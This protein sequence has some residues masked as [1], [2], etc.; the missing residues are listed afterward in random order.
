METKNNNFNRQSVAL[1]KNIFGIVMDVK[2]GIREH[3][4]N[5]SRIKPGSFQPITFWS[6]HYLHS[7]DKKIKEADTQ[8]DINNLI[9]TKNK[10]WS[11]V[12][13]E[14]F[15]YNI[16]LTTVTDNNGKTFNY[17]VSLPTVE[18]AQPNFTKFTSVIRAIGE[19]AK[20]K[21]NMDYIYEIAKQKSEYK[22]INKDLKRDSKNEKL[23][24]KISL[25]V[26]TEACRKFN[27]DQIL[28]SCEEFDNNPELINS[29]IAK[30]EKYAPFATS[31]VT[32]KPSF[33]EGC[34]KEL[35]SDRD[36]ISQFISTFNSLGQQPNT[37][38]YTILK[39]DDDP[40]KPQGGGNGG[41]AGFGGG[42]GGHQTVSLSYHSRH[43][44]K[45]VTPKKLRK[46]IDEIQGKDIED[47]L[48]TIDD[49]MGY[50]DD[51]EN[52]LN[53]TDEMVREAIKKMDKTA[54]KEDKEP[55]YSNDKPLPDKINIDDYNL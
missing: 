16:C 39:E 45:P 5:H 48:T 41:N 21:F 24:E 40:F 44:Q 14:P 52:Y 6:K 46:M 26:Y 51:I 27:L 10:S 9:K 37:D 15:A 12:K 7:Y 25:D 31:K 8:R 13:A 29:T 42:N 33:K 38:Y 49:D 36:N 34:K 18:G 23:Y 32:G 43:K 22:S 11:L 2:Q 50:F 17:F 4:K 20:N 19:Y 28:R 47:L 1:I 55:A 3:I 53:N 54:G 30:L 35:E